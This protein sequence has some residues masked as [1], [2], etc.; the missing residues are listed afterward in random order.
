MPGH[1][2]RRPSTWQRVFHDQNKSDIFSV[3][4][5]ACTLF[6]DVIVQLVKQH[7]EPTW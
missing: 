5:S 1:V 2:K 4:T 6:R 7:W 3:A